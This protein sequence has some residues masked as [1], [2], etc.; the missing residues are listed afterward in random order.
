[1]EVRVIIIGPTAGESSH[2]HGA[3]KYLDVQVPIPPGPH[4]AQADDLGEG[5]GQDQ[6]EPGDGHGGG[7]QVQ[8]GD[9]DGHGRYAGPDAAGEGAEEGVD[10]EACEVRP[11]E[12]PE[13]EGRQRGDEG[14]QGGDVDASDLVAE[15]TYHGS[16]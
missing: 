14:G 4:E 9:L 12:G 16:A 7:Q 13:E 1:M 15:E 10:D 2:E 5:R 11:R 3:D 6:G 8:A